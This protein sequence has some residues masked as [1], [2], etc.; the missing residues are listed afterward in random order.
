MAEG[1]SGSTGRSRYLAGVMHGGIGR[2]AGRA[3]GVEDRDLADLHRPGDGRR[4]LGLSAAGQ[5]VG[6][7]RGRPRC[8]GT[9]SRARRRPGEQ[10]GT[11]QRAARGQH[12]HRGLAQWKTASASAAGDRAGRGAPRLAASPLMAAA[13]PRQ[14]TTPRRRERA[15]RGTASPRARPPRSR[16]PCIARSRSP[17][18]PRAG[19]SSKLTALSSGRP[20]STRAQHLAGRVGERADHRDASAVRASGSRLPRFCQQHDRAPGGVAGERAV[21]ASCAGVR[22]WPVP[23]R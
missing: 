4:A 5:H 13:S 7:P 1:K 3:A 15:E 14:S 21:G 16:R 9:R 22:P 23:R 2:A 6:R 20:A 10:P 17:G 8:R 12:D 19:P 11:H 18:N